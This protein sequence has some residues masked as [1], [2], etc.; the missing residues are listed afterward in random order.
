MSPT[1]PSTIS[2]VT[3][4]PSAGNS[5][6]LPGHQ[7]GRSKVNNYNL[8]DQKALNLSDSVNYNFLL[9]KIFRFYKTSYFSF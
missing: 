6:S 7:S 5:N 8:L 4:K 3:V 9:N 2:S 1:T